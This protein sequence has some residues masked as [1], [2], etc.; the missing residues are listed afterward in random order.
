M[1]KGTATWK[2]PLCGCG[3]L[4]R[5]PLGAGCDVTS[6]SFVAVCLPAY[7]PFQLVLMPHEVSV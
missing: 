3:A 6:M 7:V 4:D 1:P 2:P 5:S